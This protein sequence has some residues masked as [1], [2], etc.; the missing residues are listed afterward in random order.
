MS[1]DHPPDAGLDSECLSCGEGD[2]PNECPKSKRPCGHHCNHVWTHDSC[3][4]CDYEVPNDD[5]P[6]LTCP[7]CGGPAALNPRNDA[8]ACFTP[9][10]F[11]DGPAPRMMQSIWPK[12]VGGDTV[13]LGDLPDPVGDD[14]PA[15]IQEYADAFVNAGRYDELAATASVNTAEYRNAVAHAECDGCRGAFSDSDH[16]QPMRDWHDKPH[17]LVCD[18]CNEVDRLEAEVRALTAQLDT[19]REFVAAYLA[20]ETL[21]ADHTDDRD[22]YNTAVERANNALAAVAA[23]ADPTP[24]PPEGDDGR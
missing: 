18:L 12:K 14:T 20:V 13:A 24:P 11:Y 23:T 3:H 22:A 7:K 2:P 8:L 4:W 17:R 6:A 10:C 15:P 9:G 21:I 19:H 1:K 16:T 5:T